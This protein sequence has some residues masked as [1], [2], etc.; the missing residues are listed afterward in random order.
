MSNQEIYSDKIVKGSRT[1]FFD[2]KKSQAGD[3]YLTISE[4]K[5]TESGFEQHRLMVFDEDLK[6]FVDALSKSLSKY[7]E[8][9]EPTPKAPK[10]Y[11]VKK[12]RETHTQA[13]LPWTPED[14]NKLELLFCE[15]T[16]MKELAKI[17][18]RNEGAISSRIK[19]LELK[20]KYGK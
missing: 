13:Y 3:L 20:E 1:Y 6:D 15:G 2:I 4:S 17:F 11:S 9:K 18:G 8:L 19:K 7:K 10:S 14:D 12:V 5:K 16:K